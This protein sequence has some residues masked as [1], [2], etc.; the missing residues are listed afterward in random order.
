MRAG[1][2]RVA[3]DDV[4]RVFSDELQADHFL[5]GMGAAR[6]RREAGQRGLPRYPTSSGLAGDAAQ[7]GVRLLLLDEE[8]D[9]GEDS[10]AV[11]SASL[12]S[13]SGYSVR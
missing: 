6:G 13:R 3:H 4:D 8:R 5:L 7:E 1:C 2:A 9:L 11:S 12:A 10:S